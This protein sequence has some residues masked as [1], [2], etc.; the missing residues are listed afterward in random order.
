[1]P[2]ALLAYQ[3][4]LLS[5]GKRYELVKSCRINRSGPVFF[6]TQCTCAVGGTCEVE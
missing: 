5:N 1:M 4:A 2:T 6:E 3:A